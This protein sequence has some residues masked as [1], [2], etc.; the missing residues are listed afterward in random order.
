VVLAQFAVIWK[1]GRNYGI[2]NATV[3]SHGK[4]LVKYGRSFEKVEKEMT[5]IFKD[6][7]GRIDRQIAGIESRFVTENGEPRYMTYRAYDKIQARCQMHLLT[8]I[9][10][11]KDSVAGYGKSMDGLVIKVDEIAKCV[12]VLSARDAG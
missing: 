9:S 11:V 8:E 2:M 3:D 5:Q 12:A 6:G 4:T 1:M 7:F 10:H